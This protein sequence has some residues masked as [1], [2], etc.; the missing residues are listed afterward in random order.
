MEEVDLEERL[1][2]EKVGRWGINCLWASIL[3]GIPAAIL[4]HSYLSQI[5]QFRDAQ[6]IGEILGVSLITG[7]IVGSI[8]HKIRYHGEKG[9]KLLYEHIQ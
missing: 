3:P 5:K 6:L 7:L 1:K 2:C 4:V 8:Y 9:K